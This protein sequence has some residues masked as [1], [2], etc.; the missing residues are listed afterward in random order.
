M[1]TET[2]DTAKPIRINPPEPLVFD[3]DLCM[4][5]KL[6][7]QKW[8]N[9]TILTNL[10]KQTVKY[11]VALL[12]HTLGDAALQRYNGFSFSTADEVRTT[13][14]I[15]DKFDEYVVGEINETYERFMFNNRKQ[16]D[17]ETF[18]EFLSAIRVLIKTCNY[19]KDCIDSLLRDRI[20][21]GLKENQLQEQL[22][23]ERTLTLEKCIDTCRAAE[24]AQIKRK[25]FRP[26]IV[27]KIKHD[28][29]YETKKSFEAKKENEKNEKSCKFC[30]KKHKFLKELCPAWGKTCT[31][32]KK[33][34]ILPT[35][36]YH[37]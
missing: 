7:K 23:R 3:S 10:E 17:S 25:E 1:N 6:F 33:K 24:Y 18:D 14:E 5:W 15:I 36:V 32:C 31:K 13:K 37:H 16:E 35:D 8:E 12:L 2:T 34:T 19:C 28:R 22:L 11:Q 29:K 21:L 9:Y 4:K 27:N 20:I 26:E 30:G